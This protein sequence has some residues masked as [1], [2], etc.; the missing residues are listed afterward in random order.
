MKIIKQS[1]SAAI[2]KDKFDACFRVLTQ[3]HQVVIKATYKFA[4]STQGR[5]DFSK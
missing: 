5:A 1:V 2:A 3:E 4:N